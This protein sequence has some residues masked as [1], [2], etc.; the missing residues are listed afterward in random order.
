MKNFNKKLPVLFSMILSMGSVFSCEKDDKFSVISV[1]SYRSH[2]SV[3]EYIAADKDQARN[4]LL[5]HSLEF[6]LG[7]PSCATL[8][9]KEG[10]TIKGVCISNI[11]DG[12]IYRVAVGKKY[13]GQGIGKSLLYAAMHTLYVDY[14][15]SEVS[16]HSEKASVGFYK[17]LGFQIDAGSLKCRLK[18]V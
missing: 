18:I 9:Y 13:Q 3:R 10:D 15:I 6:P 11:S 4:I 1:Q 5:E 7:M 16:L 12:Y 2:K 14:A 8:V 17:K